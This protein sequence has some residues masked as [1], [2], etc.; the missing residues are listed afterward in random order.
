MADRLRAGHFTRF[1]NHIWTDPHRVVS[2]PNSE[3][4]WL[5]TR[6]LR[7]LGVRSAEES[8]ALCVLMLETA[9]HKSPVHFVSV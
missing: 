6:A 9:L 5:C 1:A 2:L 4:G 7:V 3:H 8:V